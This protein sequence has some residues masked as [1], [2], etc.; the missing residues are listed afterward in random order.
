MHGAKVRI[1]CL[2]RP[3]ELRNLGC[4][5]S[6]G[7]RTPENHCVH[8]LRTGF[9]QQRVEPTSSSSWESLRTFVRLK[10]VSLRR[11]GLR[12][13]SVRAVARREARCEC[14]GSLHRTLTGLVLSRD[15]ESGAVIGARAHDRQAERD[16]DC[17]IPPEQ[18]DRNEALIVIHRDDEIP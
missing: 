12:D 18:F 13:V 16:V 17:L 11:V 6:S 3:I 5:R 1:T 4:S 2:D 7:T 15:A 9:T 10:R 14:D 8:G